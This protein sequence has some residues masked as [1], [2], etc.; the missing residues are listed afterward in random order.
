MHLHDNIST[1]SAT[2]R[3]H[4]LRRRHSALILMFTATECVLVAELKSNLVLP[5]C[6]LLHSNCFALQK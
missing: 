2:I 6:R 5:G 3:K 1:A 4:L